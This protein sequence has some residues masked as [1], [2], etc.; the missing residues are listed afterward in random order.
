[1]VDELDKYGGRGGGRGVV[2]GIS[3]EI[4]L[5]RTTRI[6]IELGGSLSF[7]YRLAYHRESEEP[8]YLSAENMATP[9]NAYVELYL[10]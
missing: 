1:M 3:E 2:G 9:N 10:C 6:M 5:G 4:P 7:R 8:T